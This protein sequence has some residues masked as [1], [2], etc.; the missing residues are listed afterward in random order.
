MTNLIVLIPHYNNFNE[1]LKSILSIDEE[2]GVDILI[3]DDGSTT[4]LINESV[5]NKAYSLGKIYYKY[6][7]SNSGIEVALNTGLSEILKLDYEFIG[8]LD[9]GDYCR[10]NRFTR[11]LGH[12][13][14]N[15]DLYLLGTWANMISPKGELLFVLKHP[16]DYKSIQ[17]KMYFNSMFVHPSTVFKTEVLSEIGFY[18]TEFKAA[19]DYAFFF[20]IVKRFK[21][22]NLPEAL[23]D[24]VVDDNSISSLKRKLQI[25]SRIRII[26]K[27]FYIGVY[28]IVGVI[29]NSILY[30]VSR[31][32]SNKI[33][34][35]F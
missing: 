24:Y 27:H 12:F 20:N 28:P 8:R 4:S 11:Q 9:S 6:L 15:N 22:E 21:A 10:K 19:E 23:L 26:L 2:V 1:L 34:K 14:V 32:L 3:V 13:S 33:K 5:L 16:S 35:V 18:P 25:Q 17:K 30:F 29:R 31:D 7:D